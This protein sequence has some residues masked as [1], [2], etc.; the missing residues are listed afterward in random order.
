VRGV[1]A[2]QRQQLFVYGM[3]DGAALV[4]NISQ[5]LPETANGTVERTVE[6]S[7]TEPIAIQA[8]WGWD[9]RHLDAV[10]PRVPVV[11]EPIRVGGQLRYIVTDGRYRC[12]RCLRDGLP[13]QMRQLRKDA[14]V[15]TVVIISPPTLMPW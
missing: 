2:P 6:M 15:R 11:G 14:A 12:V 4:F 5:A 8:D 7:R 10:D 9:I 1:V 3:G 13:C